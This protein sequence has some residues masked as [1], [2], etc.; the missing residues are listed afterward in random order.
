MFNNIK[1]SKHQGDIGLAYAIAYYVKFGT[2]SLPLTDSQDYDL[3]IEIDGYLKKV[4]VKT[5]NFIRDNSYQVTLVVSGGNRSGTGK[6][7]KFDKTKVDLLFILTGDGLKYSIPTSHIEAKRMLSIGKEK[8][9][10]FLV[11]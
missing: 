11:K 7:K 10:E 3:V 4:Q 1:N 9:K 5:C 6:I 8:W 2:V